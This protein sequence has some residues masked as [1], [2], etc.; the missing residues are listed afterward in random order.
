MTVR[1]VSGNSGKSKTWWILHQSCSLSIAA[2]DAGPGRLGSAASDGDWNQT[3]GFSG[4]V[5]SCLSWIWFLSCFQ[6]WV[7][8]STGKDKQLWFSVL[9][10]IHEGFCRPHQLE[11]P[12]LCW[13]SH[14]W[15]KDPHTSGDHSQ[16]WIISQMCSLEKQLIPHIH[17]TTSSFHFPCMKVDLFNAFRPYLIMLWWSSH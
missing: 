6:L 15:A 8:W 7:R 12:S 1:N 13:R 14:H 10:T 3:W 17:Q 5:R 11:S 16:V 4:V 9:V 2:S